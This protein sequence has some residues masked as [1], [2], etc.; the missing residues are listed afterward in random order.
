M[1]TA[2]EEKVLPRSG[3]GNDLDDNKKDTQCFNNAKPKSDF[4]WANEYEFSDEQIEALCDPEWVYPNLIVQTH[5]VV[6][7]APPNGG[8]TT[9]MLW[10]ASEISSNCEVLY[11]SADVAAVMRKK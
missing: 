6:I 8:K 9:L 2:I 10:I 5:I 7:P 11:I 4:D 3:F 1:S